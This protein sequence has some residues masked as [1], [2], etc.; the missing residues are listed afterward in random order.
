MKEITA[1]LKRIHF[2]LLLLLSYNTEE[3]RATSATY[4]AHRHSPCH[5]GLVMRPIKI[6]DIQA[7]PFRATSGTDQT[8]RHIQA[9]TLVLLALKMVY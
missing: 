7:V 9:V 4:Q 1:G 3:D 8:Y 5:L 2:H 6:T